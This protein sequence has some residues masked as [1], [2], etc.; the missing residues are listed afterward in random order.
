MDQDKEQNQM[1]SNASQIVKQWH[2]FFKEQMKDCQE[3]IDAAE[4]EQNRLV[5]LLESA[6]KDKTKLL[7]NK[8]DV[9]VKI[10]MADDYMKKLGLSVGDFEKRIAD[11]EIEKHK[12]FLELEAVKSNNQELEKQKEE[13]AEVIKELTVTCNH[14]PSSKELLENENKKLVEES[15]LKFQ[16][17]QQKLTAELQAKQD[18]YRELNDMKSTLDTKIHQ[19]IEQNNLQIDLLKTCQAQAQE[20]DVVKKEKLDLLEKLKNV[21]DILTNVNKITQTD[22]EDDKDLNQSCGSNS[23]G[24]PSSPRKTR[25]QKKMKI[26]DTCLQCSSDYCKKNSKN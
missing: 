9:I 15:N 26:N 11:V 25:S 17:L 18:I 4:A 8:L 22:Y 23:A 16:E 21:Q 14:L 3:K 12:L 13:A 2:T 19:E 10:S 24:T 1:N 7:K 20:L 5:G 6:S